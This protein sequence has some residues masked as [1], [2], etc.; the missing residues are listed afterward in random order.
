MGVTNSTLFKVVGDTVIAMEN[1]NSFKPQEL[2]NIVWAHATLNENNPE[3]FKKVEDHVVALDNLALAR[4][5]PQHLSNISWAYATAQESHPQLFEKV[6][7]RQDDVISKL[8][9]IFCFGDNNKIHSM[10]ILSLISFMGLSSSTTNVDDDTTVE[11]DGCC[12]TTK[13]ALLILL[14]G[15]TAKYGR[16]N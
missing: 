14:P 9:S 2:S 10:L 13:A 6:G 5:D 7:N 12:S 1:L 15:T 16:G 4:F 3:L 8:T 11:E